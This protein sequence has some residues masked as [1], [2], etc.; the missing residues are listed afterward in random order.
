MAASEQTI[1]QQRV[2]WR[3]LVGR[4]DFAEKSLKAKVYPRVYLGRNLNTRKKLVGATRFE[5]ATPCTPCKCA[6]R[7]RHAPTETEND[8]PIGLQDLECCSRPVLTA[9]NLDQ[10]FQLQS[11]LMNQLLALI[12]VHLRIVAGETIAGPANGKTLLVQQAANLPNDQH[13]L[14]LIVA[15]IAAALDRL[16]LWE[17]L[18]PIAKHVGFDAAQIA[19]FADGE[20]A[21]PRNRRQFAIVAWFQH[22]PRRA[23]SVSD[24]DGM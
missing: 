9:Q 16:E 8:S 10:L 22:M 20:I 23:P 21:F 13:V 19:H 1:G 24:Q 6:T 11:H 2:D 7:L 15:P 14:A 3:R 12:E 5:L 18:L 17:F 4:T